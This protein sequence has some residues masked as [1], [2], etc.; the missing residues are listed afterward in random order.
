MSQVLRSDDARRDLKDIGRHIA[1][2]SGSPEVA[3]RWLAAFADRCRLYS[4]QP[5][6]GELRADLDATVRQFS[7]GNYVAYFHRVPSG[8]ELLR[9]FHGSRDI[10]PEWIAPRI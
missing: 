5:D 3:I 10:P 6:M 1:A 4:T 2:E 7:F 8:I 9:V